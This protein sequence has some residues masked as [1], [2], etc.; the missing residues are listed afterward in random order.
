MLTRIVV[1]FIIVFGLSSQNSIKPMK[2]MHVFIFFFTEVF[3]YHQMSD[4]VNH[5]SV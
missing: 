3:S 5:P 1:Q 2:I 4:R